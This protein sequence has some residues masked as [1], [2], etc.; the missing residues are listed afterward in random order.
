MKPNE[1]M[2]AQA[3]SK[4]EN[5]K[6]DKSKGR[7]LSKVLIAVTIFIQLILATFL[8]CV[9]VIHG[10]FSTIRTSLIGSLMSTYR[11]QYIAKMIFSP[12]QIEAVTG[13]SKKFKSEK[14]DL[15]LVTPTKINDTSIIEEKIT[16]DSYSGYM[17]EIADPTRV[18]LAVTKFIGKVGENTSDMAAD[19]NAVAAINGGGFSDS[20]TGG[21]GSMPSDFVIQN[22]VVKNQVVSSDAECTVAAIDAGGNLIVGLRTLNELLHW[23]SKVMYACT[24]DDYPA[25]VVNGVGAFKTKDDAAY[26]SFAPRTA[27]GQKTDGTI[28][29]LVLDGRR[30]NMKGASLWDVQQIMLRYGAKCAANL[31]GG[32]S[33]AM[34]YN[35][36]II[37]N[38]SGET[39]ERTVATAFYVESAD[40]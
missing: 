10:P 5:S 20:G 33:T 24:L 38:P 19:N 16:S 36:D 39:G 12:S 9:L 11:H 4:K 13:A 8:S 40:N 17:L 30:V 32:N 37:N 34:Y 23:D 6:K 29:M 15:S 27:I 22:G 7:R 35:G 3:V 21:T 25:L 28:L 26:K 14:Q 1:L 2:P 18:K 31:D